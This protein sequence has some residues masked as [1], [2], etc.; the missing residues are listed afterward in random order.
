[1]TFTHKLNILSEE[2]EPHQQDFKKKKTS[3]EQF[4]IQ[5]RH[6]GNN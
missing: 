1:M 4:L 5:M 6:K 3:K 2:N